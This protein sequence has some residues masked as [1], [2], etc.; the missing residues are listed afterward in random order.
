MVGEKESL[1]IGQIEENYYK[2]C[3]AKLIT[4][5]YKPLDQVPVNR[6]FKMEFKKFLCSFTNY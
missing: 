1:Q 5:I 4:N 3:V 2:H 6:N